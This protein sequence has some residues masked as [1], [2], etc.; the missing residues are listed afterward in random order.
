MKDL[1]EEVQ[2]EVGERIRRMRK[3]RGKTQVKFAEELGIA[4]SELARIEIGYNT[5]EEE[6]LTQIAKAL[7]V[8]RK[9]I[10]TGEGKSPEPHDERRISGAQIRKLRESLGL[11]REELS[12]R[13]GVKPSTLHNVE[14]GHQRLGPAATTALKHLALQNK[15]SGLFKMDDR[16]VDVIIDKA[17]E[18]TYRVMED[19]SAM[20]AVES[21]TQTLGDDR[22][23]ILKNLVKN[24]VRGSTA[25]AVQS[26]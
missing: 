8:E 4:T 13:I 20:R 15:D 24:K 2:A 3:H 5:V 10:L 6:L 25:G 7:E 26:K 11:S 1:S 12:T 23:T 21:L 19:A 14:L 9:W 16:V 22:L 18:E 17:I